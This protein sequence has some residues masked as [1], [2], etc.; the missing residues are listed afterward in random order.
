[1]S[2]K[3]KEL[4]HRYVGYHYFMI[5]KLMQNIQSVKLS[6]EISLISKVVFI[7]RMIKSRRTRWAGYVARMGEK[8][9]AYRILVRKTEKKETTRKTKTYVGGQY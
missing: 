8:R 6:P 3:S 7:I 5:T 2:T 4:L 9:N 1:M